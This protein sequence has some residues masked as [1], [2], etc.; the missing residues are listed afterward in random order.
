MGSIAK[1][2]DC[3]VANQLRH[4]N[5]TIKNDRNKDIDS[6]RT[7]LNYSL[8]PERSC[9]EYEYYKQRK[10]ELYVYGRSDVKTLAGWIITAPKELPQED[11]ER[12]FR[13]TYEFL[14]NRYGAENV[15]Q[16][17]VHY[18]EGKA[19]KIKDKWT[20]D[21]IGTQLVHGRPHL[22]FCFIPVVRDTNPRHEQ[23]EKICA[24]DLINKREL[25]R[26]HTDLQKHLNDD[27]IEAKVINGETAREKYTVAQRKKEFEL[28]QEIKRLKEIEHKYNIQNERSWRK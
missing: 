26:F 8:T 5:R 20:G 11:E 25:Q 16:A 22:H 19:E 15:I 10:S 13:S 6:S 4:N 2:A 28:E 21:T 18:D 17:T 12:F 27:G 24:N 3:A 9:S 7:H 23:A 14:E 1:F